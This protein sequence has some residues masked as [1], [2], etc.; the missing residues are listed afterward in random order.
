MGPA[1][2][3]LRVSSIKLLNDCLEGSEGHEPLHGLDHI[4]KWHLS[5]PL[6]PMTCNISHGAVEM[7]EVP[8][9]TRAN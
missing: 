2:D 4:E 8:N 5:L 9:T 1:N 3:K 7:L 6:L